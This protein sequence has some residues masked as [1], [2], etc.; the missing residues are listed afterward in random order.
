MTA[1]YVRS[2]EHSPEGLEPAA[3]SLPAQ[4][5]TGDRA[6]PLASRGLQGLAH[7]TQ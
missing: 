3:P 6:K 7:Y 5:W 2:A 4:A 1:G